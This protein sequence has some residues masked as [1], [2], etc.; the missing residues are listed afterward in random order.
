MA[1]HD[2]HL[3]VDDVP[4]YR[5]FRVWVERVVPLGASFVRVTF[6]GD[7]L[8]CFAGD[9]F[10]RRIKL[11]FPDRD[12]GYSFFPD[13][14]DWWEPWR[15]LPPERRNPVRTYTVRAVR[16]GRRELDVDF[17]LHGDGGPASRWAREAAPGRPLLVIGPDSRYGE[18]GVGTEWAPPPGAARLLAAGDE[19]AAPALSAIA[20][21]LPAGVDARILIEVPDPADALPLDVA[22]GV[23]VTWLPRHRPGRP[24]ARHGDLLIPAV[25]EAARA[26]RAGTPATG[27]A[28]VAD[29][30]PRPGVVED[31][32]LWEVPE[33]AAADA[34]FYAWL[35]GEAG[36]VKI[37]RRHLVGDLGVDRKS[38]AFMG[39]WRLGRPEID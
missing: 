13:G 36:V 26:L 30:P 9:G 14:E 37:L 10:D 19:T 34:G 29:L 1:G 33:E 7:D 25:Q 4:A 31:E 17:A 5:I 20:E 12:A 18:P 24:G 23:R 15:A 39:Y 6:G 22:P 21:A 3:G 16:P 32:P 38:V 8:C 11:V 2:A 28:E 35:A 27:P